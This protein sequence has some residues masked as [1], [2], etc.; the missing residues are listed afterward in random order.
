VLATSAKRTG[1]LA[2]YDS[3]RLYY[4]GYG[5]N[6][7]TTTRF[8]RYAGNGERPLLPEHDLRTP[9]TLLRGN[10][11]YRLML[12]AAGGRAQFVRDGELV[13]DYADSQPLARGWFGFRTVDS[14]IEIRRFRVWRA[15]AP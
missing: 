14:R 10:V 15:S 3:L 12:V 8:R 4:V 9:A 6:S 7:N 1:A 11:S 2:E 5:G 13:F